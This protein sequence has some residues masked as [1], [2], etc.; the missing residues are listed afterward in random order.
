[1]RPGGLAGGKHL[2]GIERLGELERLPEA[3][4]VAG[5]EPLGQ[6][7]ERGGAALRMQLDHGA[8]AVFYEQ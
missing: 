4:A 6:R 5:G 2:G 7:A 8:H 3:R 1:M